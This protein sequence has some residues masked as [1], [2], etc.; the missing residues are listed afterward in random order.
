M[1]EFAL[2]F[3]KGVISVS[4]PEDK[5]IGVVEGKPYPPIENVEGAVKEALNR[6]IGTPPLKDIVKPGE[7]VALVVS[8][9]TRAWIRFD[10]ILPHILNELNAAGVPDQDILLVVAL[11]AHR[12]NTR[13][14]HVLVYGQEVADRV[15]IIQSYGP[16]SEDFAYIGTTSRGVPVSINKEILKADKVILTGG[17]IYHLMAGFGGGRKSI[18]PG[19]AG[20]GTIQAN[21]SLC[22]NETVG[23]GTNPMCVSGQLDGNAMNEDMIEIAKMVNPDFLFNV[24]LTA[25]GKFARFFAGH[26]LD[27]W[28][29]GCK[30]VEEIFGVPIEEKADMVIA[31]SGGYPKDINLY[32]ADKTMDNAIMACKE[33]GVVILLMELPDI[34]EPPD[35]N[36]WFDYESKNAIETALRSREF[37]VPGWTALKVGELTSKVPNIVVTL[38]QNK[39]FV[40][41]AGMIYAANVEEAIKLGEQR[42]GRRDYSILLMPYGATTMPHPMH[43]TILTVR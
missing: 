19:V 17:I 34:N 7:K 11:G 21:H 4:L 43:P 42:L 9:V 25:E 39:T 33:D 5:I 41:K 30:T 40:E 28:L 32:Q 24:T 14:E 15:R 37:T 18:L 20:Y 26:W 3:G 13:E 22:L 31:S 12:I 10:I 1:K 36:A 2:R 23:Q 29:E 35:F 27:A 38:P 16:H 6:P 8:D